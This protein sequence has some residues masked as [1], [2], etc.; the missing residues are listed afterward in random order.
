MLTRTNFLSLSLSTLFGIMTLASHPASAVNGVTLYTPYT[1]ISVP[2]GES[3]DYTIDVINNSRVVQNVAI[4]LA[5]VPKTW[6]YIIKSGGWNIKQLSI[7]PGEKKS[8]SL[9]VEVPLKVDK[10]DYRFRVLAGRFNSLPLTI[11]VSEQGTFKTEFTTTQANMQGHAKSKFTYKAELKNRTA[12]KQLYSLRAQAPR[13]WKVDFKPNNR[14]AT[15]V[16]IEANNSRD[17]T[18]EIDPPDNLKAGTY[19]MPVNARTSSTA[20]ELELEV[21]ITGSYEMELTTPTGLLSTSITAGNDR[22]VGLLIKNTGSTEL[23]DVNLSASAPSG[24][25]VVFE[26]KKIDKIEA[27]QHTEVFAEVKADKKAIAGDY[28]TSISAKTP[29][30]TSKVSLRVSVKTPMFWGWVGILVITIAVGGI[31]YL[32]QKHGRR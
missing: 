31:Y 16:E 24:W 19:K 8:L 14:Q 20:A 7:L 5:G 30:V 25:E 23:R 10:G 18:I 11:N 29:E 21:V 2:P 22:K 15:S 4:S 9:K 32:F 6:N 28:V 26:P 13:G 12:D 3:I 27:G 17:I 1:N